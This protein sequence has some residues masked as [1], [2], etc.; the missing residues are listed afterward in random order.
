MSAKENLEASDYRDYAPAIG[1]MCMQW[2]YLEGILDRHLL[3]T[4]VPLNP[5]EVCNAVTSSIDFRA[6]IQLALNLGLLKK[7]SDIWFSELLSVLNDIDNRLRP[8]RNRFAHDAI[9]TQLKVPYPSVTA[10][11]K[12]KRKKPQSRQPLQLTTYEET[13]I[14]PDEIWKTAEDIMAAAKTIGLLTGQ[15]RKALRE[16]EA[17]QQKSP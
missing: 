12:P 1:W 10:D 14:T 16:R 2:A 17:S 9:V 3:R 7:P 15:L 6:K 8:Q 4:L 11:S 5:S 13:E